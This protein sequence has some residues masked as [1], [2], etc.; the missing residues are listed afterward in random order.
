MSRWEAPAKLNLS[1][2]VGRGDAG[3]HH[4]LRSLVQTID[5]VDYLTFEEAG[6][7]EL[8]VEGADLPEGGDN[9]VWK[10]IAALR[11]AAGL[12]RPYLN[13]R[14]EKRIPA[15]AGLG[16]GSSDA[17]ASLLA[18]ARLARVSPVL[19]EA[20]APQVG[21]DVPFLMVGGTAWMEGYGEQVDPL[22]VAPD[23]A[24]GVVVP[25]FELATASVYGAWDLL[26]EPTGPELAG[27]RLPPSLRPLGP[28][29]NDLTPAA[30]DLH[31]DLADW[32]SEMSALLERPL[33]MT[34]SGPALFAFF[35]DLEE[36]T[37]AMATTPSS[38]RAAIAATPR[39][40]GPK[41]V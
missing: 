41:A 3:G 34:G 1:L 19:A 27:R 39:P 4:P 29:R 35:G 37:S 12:T 13:I 33:L 25:P 17:A 7:D 9:L 40:H 36:A 8:T 18:T 32:I 6:S 23:Y 15:A 38:L 30:I 2:L 5:W 28:L 20:V 16:G 22:Q 21:A 24:L 11:Q 31:P 26:G 14:L 10:A